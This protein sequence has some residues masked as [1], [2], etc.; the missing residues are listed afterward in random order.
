MIDVEFSVESGPGGDEDNGQDDR[1]GEG[2][3]HGNHLKGV[4]VVG[5]E[6]FVTQDGNGTYRM[7]RKVTLIL[8]IHEHKQMITAA[9]N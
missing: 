2:D 8:F 3:D 9:T 5:D 6:R 1:D 7:N 4:T